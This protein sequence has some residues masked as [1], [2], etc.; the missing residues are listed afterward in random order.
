MESNKEA[1]KGIRTKA[2]Q[3]MADKRFQLDRKKADEN[4]DGELTKYEE[5]KAEA[6]QKAQA[7][8]ELVD[9]ESLPE[10]A[11]GGMPCGMDD[12]LMVDPISGNE[13]PPGSSGENVRDDIEIMISEGEYVLPADVV[14]WH[15]LKHIMEMQDEAKMGLM[16]MFA[17]GLIQYVEED[18][19]DVDDGDE[20]DT[21]DDEVIETPDGNEIEVASFEVEEEDPEYEETEEYEDSD[22]ASEEPLGTMVKQKYAFIV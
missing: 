19:V 20:G 3:D 16:T 4:G 9:E 7:D 8:G 5:A 18:P 21:D 12:G 13:I 22:Y 14:K 2:G 17:D 1:R 11:H 10:M 15:G 6:V